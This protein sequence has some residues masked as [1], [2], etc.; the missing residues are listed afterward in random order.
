MRY[1]FVKLEVGESN[2]VDD[3]DDCLS[4]EAGE[5]LREEDEDQEKGEEMGVKEGSKEGGKVLTV[6]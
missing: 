6:G 5:M 2:D 4:K 1:V 3:N